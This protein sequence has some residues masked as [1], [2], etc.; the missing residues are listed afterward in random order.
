MSLLQDKDNLP[1]RHPPYGRRWQKRN[2][3]RCCRHQSLHHLLSWIEGGL[4]NVHLPR[5][6]DLLACEPPPGRPPH[7]V[8]L[9]HHDLFQARLDHFNHLLARRWG[10]GWRNACWNPSGH[11]PRPWSWV[12]LEGLR[13]K[14]CLEQIYWKSCSL[15]KNISFLTL[16]FGCG[17]PFIPRIG[18]SRQKEEFQV[19]F[20][21]FVD[22]VD[23]VLHTTCVGLGHD[24]LY[25]W[26]AK[27]PYSPW[28]WWPQFQLQ[29]HLNQIRRQRGGR[30]DLAV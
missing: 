17:N 12:H 5:V 18:L 3:S 19:F 4:H 16:W 26:P 8:S 30:L 20:H 23:T 9:T 11:Q 15:F 10:I 2:L 29:S 21:Q 22:N 7:F 1:F 14:Y 27:S 25:V 24:N 13:Q 28:S 6:D